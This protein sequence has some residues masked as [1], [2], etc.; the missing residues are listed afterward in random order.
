MGWANAAITRAT[1]VH[2]LL[3][4]WVETTRIQPREHIVQTVDQ[5]GHLERNSAV[6]VASDSLTTSFDSSKLASLQKALTSNGNVPLDSNV[7][8]HSSQSLMAGRSGSPVQEKLRILWLAIVPLAIVAFLIWFSVIHLNVKLCNACKSCCVKRRCQF[9]HKGRLIYEWEQ[10]S[11]KVLLYIKLPRGITKRK[12]EVKIWPRHIKI[13]RSGKAAFIRE[14][15]YS[16]IDTSASTWDVTGD[17]GN[18]LVVTLQKDSKSDWPC[19]FLS[20]QLAANTTFA[21]VQF[22]EVVEESPDEEH[23]D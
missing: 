19:V 12:I 1:C 8:S 23:S 9:K 4:H 16:L 21:D 6:E 10:T 17:D 5:Q 11:S 3:L 20:H 13:G 22:G 14:E 15:L 18:D 2:I 7:Y